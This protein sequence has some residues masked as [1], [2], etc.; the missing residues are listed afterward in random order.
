MSSKSALLSSKLCLALLLVM[1]TCSQ[2]THHQT[3][4]KTMTLYFETLVA[5]ANATVITTTGILVNTALDGSALYMQMSIVFTNKVYGGS[6]IEIQG[7]SRP[8]SEGVVEFSV[9]G[10][11]GMFRNGKGYATFEVAYLDLPHGYAVSRCNIT[12]QI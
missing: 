10:G 2:S 8:N 1:F 12:M 4:E 5:G 11:T 3:K 6:T 7:V 9:V